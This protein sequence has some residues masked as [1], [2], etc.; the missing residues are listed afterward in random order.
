MGVYIQELE[1]GG[2]Y[3]MQITNNDGRKKKQS[4]IQTYVR[5]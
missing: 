5:E 3:E 4:K 2:L 1:G